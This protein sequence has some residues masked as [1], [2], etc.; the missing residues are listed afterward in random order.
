MKVKV[1]KKFTKEEQL[2][3]VRKENEDLKE[4]VIA[5]EEALLTLLFGGEK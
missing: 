3:L 2:E 4:R 1:A 5:T